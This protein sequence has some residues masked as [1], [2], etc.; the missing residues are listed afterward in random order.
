MDLIR[1]A[2]A[3]VV[4]GLLSGCATT[5]FRSSFDTNTVGQP[6]S[7]AQAIGTVAVAGDPGSVVVVS[8]ADLPNRWVETSRGGTAESQPASLQANLVRAPGPGTYTFSAFLF[9]PSAPSNVATI[10]FEPFG[11]PVADLTGGFLHLDFLQ[12]NRVRIDDNENTIFGT[13]PRDQ[14]FVVQVT[15]HLTP[16]PT[17]HIVLSGAGASGE[18]D[19]TLFAPFVPK[20]QQ[21]GAVR[22]WMGF[23]WSGR[24]DA[25]QIVVT[26]QAP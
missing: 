26:H 24:F 3:L 1:R 7:P 14:V 2:A 10:Q 25:T 4:L 17:A 8:L 20:A 5:V 22:L 21:F 13:F 18:A 12:S 16:A 23:P 19:Y 15:L 9:V 6:P 11:W